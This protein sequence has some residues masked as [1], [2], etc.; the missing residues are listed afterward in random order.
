MPAYI[1]A[2]VHVTDP[3][4]YR[5]YTDRT[6]NIIAQYGGRFVIRGGR[7][8]TVEGEPESRRIVL[9]E[10]PTRE[11]AEAV[12]DSPEYRAARKL[13]AEAAT[14]QFILVEGVE[15]TGAVPPAFPQ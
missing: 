12:Y 13:R 9:I 7:V 14:G 1:L 5:H 11:Q 3:A 15:T 2:R 10:F 8:T 6:P 4:S